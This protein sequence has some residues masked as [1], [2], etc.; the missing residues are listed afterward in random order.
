MKEEECRGMREE[1]EISGLNADIGMTDQLMDGIRHFGRASIHQNQLF[2]PLTSLLFAS[3]W[4]GKGGWG[5]SATKLDI[6][7]LP[8]IV[9]ARLYWESGEVYG[10]SESVSKC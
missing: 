9:I 4:L 6:P 8:D 5:C 3:F 1:I 7:L 10:V 2:V